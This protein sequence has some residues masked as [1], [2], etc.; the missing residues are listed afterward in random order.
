MMWGE[1]GIIDND[2]VVLC[3][4]DREQVRERNND[5]LG[6]IKDDGEFR[7]GDGR[8]AGA[9]PVMAGKQ[10]SRKSFARDRRLM[11][12]TSETS[13][14]AGASAFFHRLHPGRRADLRDRPCRRH[15][16]P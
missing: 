6:V 7:H 16:R 10:D 3:A 2:V 8:N 9:V 11:I 1:S 13:C 5:F 4:A 14:P 12:R 15:R